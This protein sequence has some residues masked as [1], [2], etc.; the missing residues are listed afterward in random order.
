MTDTLQSKHSKIF[1]LGFPNFAPD[2][3]PCESFDFKSSDI[4]KFYPCA[5]HLWNFFNVACK[6]V[7]YLFQ[8]CLTQK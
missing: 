5:K 8:P 2:T 1:R 3:P 4:F 7:L 6:L